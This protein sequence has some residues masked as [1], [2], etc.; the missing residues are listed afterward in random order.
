MSGF[1]SFACRY[2]STPSCHSL[3]VTAP[4]LFL[5]LSL[6]PFLP[7]HSA[8]Q[9]FVSLGGDFHR[10][11]SFILC[12]SWGLTVI[13]LYFSA[14]CVVACLQLYRNTSL[15]NKFHIINIPTGLFPLPSFACLL[16][17]SSLFPISKLGT[18]CTAYSPHPVC[19]RNSAQSLSPSACAHPG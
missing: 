13:D 11:P 10:S 19:L 6:K 9:A 15:Q 8:Y 1:I 16:E 2:P 14:V 3:W 17:R 5:G 4:L 12:T 18:T 7:L